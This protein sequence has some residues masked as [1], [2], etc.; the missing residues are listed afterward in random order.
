[1][2]ASP[3]RGPKREGSAA[4]GNQ[5]LSASRGNLLAAPL[6]YLQFIALRGDTT[7]QESG[8][9]GSPAA[10]QGKLG[11]IFGIA[12]SSALLFPQLPFVV[13]GSVY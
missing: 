10:Y 2:A 9:S 7:H 11:G 6:N 3:F 4:L 12:A 8:V 5:S 1:M 13:F